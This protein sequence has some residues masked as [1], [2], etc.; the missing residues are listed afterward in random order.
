MKQQ[1]TLAAL[2]VS[3]IA[4][5]IAYT[6]NTYSSSSAHISQL[7]SE[8]FAQTL[9]AQEIE[10]LRSSF[11][12]CFQEREAAMMRE[13]H[14]E[15]GISPELVAQ[16]RNSIARESNASNNV[17][18]QKYAEGATK[19]QQETVEFVQAVAQTYGIS[20]HDIHVIAANKGPAS[21]ACASGNVIAVDERYFNAYPRQEQQFIIA[22]ELCHV[23]HNDAITLQILRGL[24]S[25]KTTPEKVAEVLGNV[26]RF[27]EERADVFAMMRGKEYTNG[28]LHF[29]KKMDA[30]YGTHTASTHPQWIQRYNVA[31]SV[32]NLIL[33]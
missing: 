8:I 33:A 31:E 28:A 16:Q 3:A 5:G 26:S 6:Y 19:A 11:E 27:I 21:P 20:P 22:H 30:T 15:F 18:K 4:C 12:T 14:E 2:L 10:P 32:N 7:K 25:G 24:L 17:L 29:C 1:I 13:I 23:V 9:T